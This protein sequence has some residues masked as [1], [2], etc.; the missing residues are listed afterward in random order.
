MSITVDI[1]ESSTAFN[2][3]T[4]ANC[5]RNAVDFMSSIRVC[6]QC[7]L[8][9]IYIYKLT[10]MHD[11]NLCYCLAGY[12]S[13]CDLQY[14]YHNVCILEIF[15]YLWW[16]CIWLYI[17]ITYSSVV[18]SLYDDLNWYVVLT[19]NFGV[20]YFLNLYLNPEYVTDL[21]L[22]FHEIFSIYAEFSY[23]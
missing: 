23:V 16:S 13:N 4:S 21:L 5:G 2:Q 15:S 7:V 20:C 14:L 9:I 18:L 11:S 3:W 17:Y 1:Y 6:A 10:C 8:H 19:P 22:N 12:Y